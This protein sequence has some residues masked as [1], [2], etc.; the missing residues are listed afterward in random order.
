MPAGKG[1]VVDP[2]PFQTGIG[3]RGRQGLFEQVGGQIGPDHDRRPGKRG[4]SV[5]AR[6]RDRDAREQEHGL[7]EGVA[8]VPDRRSQ[9]AEGVV[10]VSGEVG[11]NA[12]VQV[13]RRG[14]VE[15]GPG[16]QRQSRDRGKAKSEESPPLRRAAYPESLTCAKEHSRTTPESISSFT[17]GSQSAPSSTFRSAS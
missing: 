13:V 12:R 8:E 7:R 11:E 3:S 17:S 1:V 16:A 15:G 4:P 5:S 10:A 9:M 14:E 6:E 2:S